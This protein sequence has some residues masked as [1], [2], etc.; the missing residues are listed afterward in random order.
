MAQKPDAQ[1]GQ[2]T[3]TKE[4]QIGEGASTTAVVKK[5]EPSLL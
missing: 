5:P 2:A 1:T 3:A 4:K